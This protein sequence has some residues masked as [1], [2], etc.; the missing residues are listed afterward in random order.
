[1]MGFKDTG[2]QQDYNLSQPKPEKHFFTAMKAIIASSIL[3]LGIF[4]GAASDQEAPVLKEA[5]RLYEIAKKISDLLEIEKLIRETDANGSGFAGSAKLSWRLGRIYYKLGDWSDAETDKIRYFSLCVEHTE[6]TVKI[7][8]RSANGFFF[9]GLCTGK[10]GETKGLWA[11]LGIISPLKKDMETAIGLDPSVSEGG[12]HRALGNLYLQLPRF[13]GRDLE[14][15]IDHF[16]EAVRL[17]PK[18]GENYLGLDQ[19]YFKNDEY[20]SARNT[21]RTFLEVAGKLEEDESVRG[22]VSETR[23]F[24]QQITEQIDP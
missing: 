8:P 18:Y 17:G 20:I 4:L 23:T 3:S 15:A 13:F 10:L 9:R 6:K 1:M 5:D 2:Y 19:A 7:N 24:L 12:P 14:R 21:L 16:R 11:S 22:F